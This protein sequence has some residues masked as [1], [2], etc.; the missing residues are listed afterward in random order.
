MEKNSVIKIGDIKM[1]LLNK[2]TLPYLDEN[3]NEVCL[4]V[5]SDWYTVPEVGHF[6]GLQKG[7]RIKRL[8]QV[9]SSPRASVYIVV[10]AEDIS[11]PDPLLVLADEGVSEIER[12]ERHY[13]AKIL[14]FSGSNAALASIV[15]TIRLCLTTLRLTVTHLQEERNKPKLSDKWKSIISGLF[16]KTLGA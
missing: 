10:A 11:K 2:P 3:G 14:Q 15:E 16:N 4:E 1:I 12:M 8:Y 13:G 7:D 9:S 6:A 5:M